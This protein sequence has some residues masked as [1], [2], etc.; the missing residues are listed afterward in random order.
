MMQFGYKMRIHCF[1][2]CGI[3][4]I[5]AHERFSSIRL[6]SSG[7]A[8]QAILAETQGAARSLKYASWLPVVHA[9]CLNQDQKKQII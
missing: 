4:Q 6:L 7:F 2:S 3:W 8:G 9:K 5:R 1:W